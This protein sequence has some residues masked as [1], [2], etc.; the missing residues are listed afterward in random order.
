MKLHFIKYHLLVFNIDTNLIT[1]LFA[2]LIFSRWI[3]S[4]YRALLLSVLFSVFW[5]FF[6]RIVSRTSEFKDKFY[7]FTSLI[8]KMKT[9]RLINKEY[10]VFRL[11]SKWKAR[12]QT[13]DFGDGLSHSCHYRGLSKT[14]HVSGF[15]PCFP[16][17]T[18][19]PSLCVLVSQSCLTLCNSMDWSLPGS[20]VHGI[21]QARI[22]EWVAI[23]FSVAFFIFS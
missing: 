16:S 18:K 14:D 3:S 21:L 10:Q 5:H 11:N 7:S 9:R 17:F 1:N 4:A 19:L 13:S 15:N 23:S 2:L 12:K 8:N 22:L 6:C 20:S